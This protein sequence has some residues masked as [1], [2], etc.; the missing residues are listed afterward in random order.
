MSM[1]TYILH[2]SAFGFFEYFLGTD[3]MG[4]LFGHQLEIV[5]I[6]LVS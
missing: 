1:V 6:S 2:H 5:G 4:V 3:Q